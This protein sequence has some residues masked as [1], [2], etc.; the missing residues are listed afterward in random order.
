MATD[1]NHVEN[2]G[3]TPE[4][5]LF[6]DAERNLDISFEQAIPLLARHGIIW[7][8]Q[9]YRAHAYG[10]FHNQLMWRRTLTRPWVDKI[11]SACIVLDVFALEPMDAS[12]GVPLHWRVTTFSEPRVLLDSAAHRYGNVKLHE[13]VSKGLEKFLFECSEKEAS[14][15]G[16]K[17]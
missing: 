4:E 6:R 5:T 10:S 8:D 14:R 15:V 7:L 12:W 1:P 11:G 13:T 3:I 16:R 17:L 9:S 2:Q